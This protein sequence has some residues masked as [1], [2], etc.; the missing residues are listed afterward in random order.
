MEV[1]FSEEEKAQAQALREAFNKAFPGWVIELSV[2]TNPE[3]GEARPVKVKS[4]K[5]PDYNPYKGLYGA[6][7]KDEVEFFIKGFLTAWEMAIRPASAG[8]STGQAAGKSV[9]AWR[10]FLASFGQ[11]SPLP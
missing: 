2:C 11:S 4:A 6:S 5:E 3:S 1:V 10:A 9:P 7:S 8:T